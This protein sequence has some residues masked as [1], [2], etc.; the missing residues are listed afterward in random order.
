MGITNEQYEKIIRFLDADMEPEEMEAFEKE[1]ASNPEMRHQ[2]DF[3]QSVRDGFALRNITSL[4]DTAPVKGD[5]ATPKTPGKI[6]TMRKWWA[7][8]A[9]AVAIIALVLFT[10]LW[11]K[12]EK[13]PGITNRKDIDTIHEKSAPPQIVTA[14]AKDSSGEIEL[15]SLFRQYFKK[16]TLPEEYPI[17]LAEALTDYDSGNYTTLQRLNLNSIPQTRGV[18][19]ADSKENILQLG[20]YY[21]GLA[22]LQTNNT[23]E[24]VINLEWVLNNHPGNT[25]RDKAQWYLALAYLKEHKPG[26][27]KELL[28]K[29]ISGSR[30]NTLSKHA[31]TLL[32]SLEKRDNS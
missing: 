22:F 27:A 26:K 8:S 17:F 4:T 28:K 20:H 12:Q 5:P 24:A 14:P 29:I 13:N 32:K 15:A 30:E 1:L 2:L 18:G 9:A 16:D 23:R 21:K 25:L 19:E 3:E 10:I 7:I 31:N 6:T 11:Q